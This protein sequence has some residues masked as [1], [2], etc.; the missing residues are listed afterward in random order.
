[1]CSSLLISAW[2]K[3]RECRRPAMASSRAASSPSTLTYTR[4]ARRSGLVSTPVTVTKP[5]RGSL[6]PA[7]RCEDRTSRTASLTRRIRAPGILEHF[8][9]G[10]ER[11]LYENALGKLRLDIAPELGPGVVHD[12]RRSPHESSGERGALPQVVM[13]GLRDG[14]AEAALQLRLQRDDLLA[15]ALEAPVAGKVKLDLDQADEAHAGSPAPALG[16]LA[17]H[18]T[19]LEHLEDVAFLDV[20]IPLERDSALVSLGHLADVVLEAP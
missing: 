7:A 15:L 13:V 16:E 9:A 17:L 20:L 3:P 4:A 2:R 5:M 1:M 18:L 11:S 12:R 6:R 8:L 19:R 10:N 14:G